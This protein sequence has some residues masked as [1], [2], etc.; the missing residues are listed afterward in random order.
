M[1]EGRGEKCGKNPSLSKEET[2][3]QKATTARHTSDDCRLRRH[4]ER[5]SVLVKMCVY[6]YIYV[7]VCVTRRLMDRN[8]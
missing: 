5:M 8:N 1:C 3:N 7:C 4:T 6:V 2:K